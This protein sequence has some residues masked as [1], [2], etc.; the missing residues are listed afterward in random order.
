MSL[1][2][3]LDALRRPEPFDVFCEAA[4]ALE[5]DTSAKHPSCIALQQA[6]EA[7]NTVKAQTLLETGLTGPALGK[8]LRESRVEAIAAVLTKDFVNDLK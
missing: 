6:K 7:A 4:A 8:A 2:E 3:G 5:S 1:L